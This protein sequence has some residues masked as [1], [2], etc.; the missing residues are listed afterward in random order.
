MK[1]WKIFRFEFKYQLRHVST[2]LLLAAF[3]LFGFTILRMVTLTDDTYLNAPGT[4]AFFSIFGCAIWVIIGGVV[5]GDAATRDTQT[6]M[7]PLT[8]TAP[9]SKFTHLGARFL[10]ALALNTV[11]ML[12]LYTGFVLSLYGPGSKAQLLGPFRIDS[13]LTNFGFLV[14]PTVFATTAIQFTFGTWSRR[15]VASSIASLA[16]IVFSQF[17]GTTV[18]YMLEWKVLGSLMDLLGTSIAVE[19]EGWTPIEKNTRLILLEGAWLWNRLTWLGVA[20]AALA[21]TYFR[22]RFEHIAP[23]PGWLGRAGFRRDRLPSQSPALLNVTAPISSDSNAVNM[24]DVRR[25]FG[26]PTC[27][28]QSFAIARASFFSV[29]K[30][31]GGIMPVA[32]LAIGT[33]LFATEYMEWFGVPLFARTAE[34][35]RILTP[36]LNSYQTQ[37]IIIPLLSIFYAGELVWREREAGVSELTDIAPVPEWVMFLGKFLGLALIIA[38]WVGFVMIA[39]LINQLVMHYHHFEITLY[40]KALFG[41]QFTNYLLFALLVF[42][43]HVL[44]NQKY[45]AHMVAFACYGFILFSSM[46]GVGHNLLVYASDPGWSYSDM[47]GFEPFLV[48]WLWFKLHWVL[49]AF[50]LAVVATLCWVRS[51]ENGLPARFQLAKRRF[52]KHKPAL[53]IASI[54]VVLS[55]TFIFYNTNVLNVYTNKNDQMQMRAAYERLYGKYENMPQPDIARTKLNVEI[56]PDEQKAT[57]QATYHLVNHNRISINAIH[58]STIPHVAISAVSFDQQTAATVIDDQLGYRIYALK[59]QLVPGDSV[60]MTFEIQIKRNGFTNNGADAS[61]VANG[62]HITSG[63]W[64]PVIGYDENRRIRDIKD[65]ETFGLAPRPARPSLY[66]IAA[67]FKAR[68]AVKMDFEAVIGTSQNQIAVA[69]G[70]LRNTWKKGDRS[71][72]HYATNAPIQ[73]EYAF[74]SANYAVSEKRITDGVFKPVTIQIFYHPAHKNNVERM[75]KSAEASLRYYS[76]EFGPYPY[77]HFRVLERP[78]SGRGMHAEP[79]TI[80]YQEGYSLMNPRMNGLDLPYHIMAHEVAHQ[81]WGFKLTAAAVEGSG[82][83]IESLATYSAMQVVE[84]MLGYEHLLRYL[85]QMRQEYEVPRSP[86]APPLLRAN[87][88]F[89]NYRKGPFALFALRNYIGKDSVNNALRKLLTKYPTKPPL[90]TTL[91]LYDELLTVTPDSLDYLTYDLF[92]QN[93]FW[94]LGT[95]QAK[96]KQTPAGTW[97]MSLEVEARKVVVDSIGRKM[98]VPMNDWI[99]IGVYGSPTKNTASGKVLYLRKHRI[100]TGKQTINCDVPEKPH[101]AGIDP[102]QLLID[103]NPE[104]NTQTAA[105]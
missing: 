96:A 10:A 7:Y 53:L 61:V 64:M 37:W 67:R 97:Q 91:D 21:F 32:I 12:A 56:Y 35:L 76:Q 28:I 83:L 99:E 39:G 2:W 19:M 36:P 24:P 74:F 40:I 62:T 100:H 87:N 68:H 42:V 72:F 77:S 75:L 54:L 50:L 90:P 17:G 94:E 3:F 102:N 4:I 49:W 58:L 98:N 5:G 105:F 47:R 27:T 34:V 103:L 9:V 73:N 43:I 86:A 104:N 82:L 63:A 22:F 44:V 69:P 13:Y 31:W 46:L 93:S 29:L 55:G 71:Y 59:N 65:R 14:F 48:P 60:Q 101:R 8:Y 88:A 15:A 81:W 57:I 1:F 41:I 51:R 25:D 70:D 33:G 18:R 80:D 84:K 45:I 78:G 89:M 6:L 79:M 16:I 66:D 52:S 30:S 11:I 23:N 92:A 38:I 85:S 95:K 26:L 20:A